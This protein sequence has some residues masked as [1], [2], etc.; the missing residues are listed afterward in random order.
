MEYDPRTDAGNLLTASYPTD[1]LKSSVV[2]AR[3]SEIHS[4]TKI[5]A[6]AIGFRKIPIM[7][8]MLN[9]GQQLHQIDQTT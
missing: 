4:Y 7:N 9:Y 5:H 2:S 3:A 1:D 8:G 6:F